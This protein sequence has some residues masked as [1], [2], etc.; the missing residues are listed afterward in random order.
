MNNQS[1]APASRLRP[2]SSRPIQLC[3]LLGSLFAVTM[4]CTTGRTDGATG[5]KIRLQVGDIKEITMTTRADTS[6]QLTATSDNQEVVDVSRKQPIA[7]TGS[8]Q[9]SATGPAVFLIKGVTVGTARV[10]FSEKQAGSSGDGQVRKT[11]TVVV[12]SK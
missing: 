11:Y 8:P 12:S 3:M 5:P 2:C 6:W 1:V 9:A 4:A 10:V 7:T